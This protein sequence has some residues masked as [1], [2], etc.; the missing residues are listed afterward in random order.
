MRNHSGGA[1]SFGIGLNSSTEA[2]I[3]GVSDVLPKI[4]LYIDLFFAAQG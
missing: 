1:I 3:V 2:E 4:I